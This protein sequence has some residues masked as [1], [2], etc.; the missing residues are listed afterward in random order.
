MPDGIEIEGGELGGGTIESHG[1]HRIAMAFALVGLK[2][3]GVEIE[4]PDCVS[5]T[6]PNYFEVLDQ[7]RK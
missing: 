6:F 7:L 5:K 1:D 4:D 2:T 3:A